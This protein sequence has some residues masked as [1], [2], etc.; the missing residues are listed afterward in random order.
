MATQDVED[1]E[2]L[3]S[4]LVDVNHAS[5]TIDPLITSTSSW[6]IPERFYSDRNS[7]DTVEKTR[8]TASTKKNGPAKY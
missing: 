8:S 7:Y 3:I 5:I 6:F 2:I 1:E 4:G